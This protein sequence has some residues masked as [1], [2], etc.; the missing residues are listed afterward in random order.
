[1][2]ILSR[3]PLRHVVIN[4]QL[5][6]RERYRST[7]PVPISAVFTWVILGGGQ[8][9]GKGGILD[10]DTAQVDPRNNG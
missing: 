1:M 7:W 5:C 4:S 9:K 2:H 6:S 3:V 8:I 10:V